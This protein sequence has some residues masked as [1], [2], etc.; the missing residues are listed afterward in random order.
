MGM[1]ETDVVAIGAGPAGLFAVFECG[2]RRINGEILNFEYST[3]KGTPGLGAD[4]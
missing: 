1:I 3:P 2:H 4:A